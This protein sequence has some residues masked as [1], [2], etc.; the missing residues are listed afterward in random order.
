FSNQGELSGTA[1]EELGLRPGIKVAYRAGDQPNNALSLNVLN[2]GELAATAGTSGVVYGIG[3]EPNYDLK[4]RVNTFVHVNHTPDNARYGVL[5]CVNGTGILNRWL[6]NN[7]VGDGKTLSYAEMND[8]AAQA[9]VGS[10]GLLILPFGNGA[11]R[12]LDNQDLGGSIHGLKFN[13]HNHSHLLRAAQEG[14]VF[15]LNYGVEIMRNMGI[16][17]DSVRAGYT[18]MFL[19]PL[20]AEA[21]ATVTGAQVELHNTDGSQGAA[22][23]AG[24]GSGIYER[25]ESAFIGLRSERVIEPNHALAAGYRKAYANWSRELEFQLGRND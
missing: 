19:S 5:L 15:A 21:F 18:N 23:G 20:F 10:E 2:P 4:S 3:D 16:Q 8:L 24:I 25:H 14:I 6:R 7:S 13:I 11:E 12:T 1:A 9:P 22:R 17:I